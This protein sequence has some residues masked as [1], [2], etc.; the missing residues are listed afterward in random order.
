MNDVPRKKVK[1]GVAETSPGSWRLSFD[2]KILG[3][4]R[5]YDKAR[6][7]REAQAHVDRTRT[8]K[9]RDEEYEVDPTHVFAFKPKG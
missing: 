5:G 4:S 3:D 2:G 8:W 9:Y 7:L 1:V 6:A